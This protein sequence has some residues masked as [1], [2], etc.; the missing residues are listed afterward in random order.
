MHTAIQIVGGLLLL[1]GVYLLAGLAWALVGG[2]AAL[3][4]G[5]VLTEMFA[6]PRRRVDDGS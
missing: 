2:G 4:A 1:A 3:V 5:S 6:E